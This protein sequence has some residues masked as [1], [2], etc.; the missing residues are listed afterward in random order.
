[1]P[2]WIGA[3]YLF[4]SSTSFADPA[5]TVGRAFTDTFAGI[6]QESVAPFIAA[7]LVGAAIGAVQT[8]I[9]HPRPGVVPEPLDLPA[10]VHLTTHTKEEP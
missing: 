10:P 4:T 3:A 5:V 6:A 1:V 8:E 9:F 2:A 7:Q